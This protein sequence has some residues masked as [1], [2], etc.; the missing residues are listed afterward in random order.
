[1]ITIYTD[2]AA[3][4]NPGPGGYGAVLLFNNKGE[5]LRKELSEGFRLTTNNRMELLAVI[6]ALQALKVTG[7]PVRIFSD[8]K[9]VVDAIEKGWL[10]GWQKKGFKDKKNPDLWLRYIPLHL[11]YKPKFIWVKGHAGNPENERCDQLAVAAAEG[12]NL[13]ADVGYEE[14]QR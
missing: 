7:I 10:W 9:Y 13:P 2:G 11:K 5:I 1:M 14:S 3:K 8:S 6:R 12:F 4:G